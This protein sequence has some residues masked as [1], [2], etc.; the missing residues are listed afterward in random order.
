MSTSVGELN[1]KLNLELARL[2][3]QIKA[4]NQKIASMGRRMQSDLQ[5]AARAINS[6]LGSIGIGVGFGAIVSFGKSILDLGGKITDLA[7]QANLSTDAFQ[8]FANA[9]KESGVT[10]EQIANAFNKLAESVQD[11]A[12][13]SK[14]AV[15]AFAKLHLTAA[16][17]K[18]LRPEEQFTLIAAQIQDATD[19][20]AAFNAALDILGSKNAPKLREVLQRLG[21]EGFGQLSKEFENVRFTPEQLKTLDEAG[22]ALQRIWDTIKLISA[23][24]VTGILA[25]PDSSAVARSGVYNP[26]VGIGG[27]SATDQRSILSQQ[28]EKAEKE[29]QEKQKAAAAEAAALRERAKKADEEAAKAAAKLA[30]ETARLT[31]IQEAANL[32]GEALLYENEKRNEALA[33]GA[34]MFEAVLTPMEKYQKQLEKVNE[35]EKQGALTGYQAVR[36]RADLHEK[37]SEGMPNLTQVRFDDGGETPESLI[38]DW[39]VFQKQMFEIFDSV[40]DRAAS[41][42]AD[43]LISGENAFKSLTTVISKA[44]LEMVTRLAIINPIL[45]TL[46]GLSG[47]SVLPT[48]FTSF[49]G[50]RAS[51]GPVAAGMLYQVNENGPE[52]FRPNVSGTIIPNDRLGLQGSSGDSFSFVYNIQAGVSRAE[53]LPILRQQSEA[54]IGEIRKRDRQRR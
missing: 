43:M 50:A 11:A 37:M 32:A 40:G 1:I 53:L 29:R 47:T 49:G 14:T 7:T 13:G 36:I 22:D 35:L 4:S 46:F 10:G 25:P 18:A 24:A 41:A 5:K 12:E 52:F 2:D 17:L 31:A 23:R 15:D 51:G 38:A 54:T 9:G 33:E 8:T 26:S 30:E 6:T 21:T 44:I 42:F 39:T 45:N 34:R 28:E 19:K 3:A 16:G 20:E 27:K 48:L